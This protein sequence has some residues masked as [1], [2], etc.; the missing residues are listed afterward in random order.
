MSESLP[1]EQFRRAAQQR[2]PLDVSAPVQAPHRIRIVE[3]DEDGREVVSI[4]AQ[5]DLRALL[6]VDVK[7]PEELHK[8]VDVQQVQLAALRRA[9]NLRYEL[10]RA[11]NEAVSVPSR[12]DVAAALAPAAATLARMREGRE[13]DERVREAVRS[14]VRAWTTLAPTIQGAWDTISEAVTNAWD[15]IQN[16][17]REAGALPEEAPTDPRAR[18]LWAKQRAGKGPHRPGPQGSRRPR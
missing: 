16:L 9:M 14:Y 10:A 11:A 18:A 2:S 15:P 12:A 4:T 3:I 6:A 8:R 5:G 17:L 1:W 7:L 13:A